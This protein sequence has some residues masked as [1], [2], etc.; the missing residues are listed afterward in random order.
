MKNFKKRYVI[1]LIIV[2]ALLVVPFVE[3]SFNLNMDKTRN[4]LKTT[5]NK[6][7][8]EKAH[9]GDL[10]K[11]YH[12][13]FDNLEDFILY[14]PATTMRVN[15]IAIIKPKK[16]QEDM[17]LKAMENR[18]DCQKKVFEG[19]GPKQCKLLDNSILY[20]KGSFIIYIVGEDSKVIEEAIEKG[21]K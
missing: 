6:E 5:V 21:A 15:E 4:L 11:F 9:K 19:Y 1:Y 13:D 20:K 12:V 7:Y 10:R 2:L 16:G 8:V 17:F 18:R 14:V 3:E